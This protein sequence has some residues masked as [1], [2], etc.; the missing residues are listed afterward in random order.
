MHTIPREG[1]R[2]RL[3]S[4]PDDPDPIQVGQIGTVVDV[5]RHGDGPDG[6]LQIDVEWDDGRTL[7]LVSPPD[8][9]EIVHAG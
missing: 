9:F 5:T 3:Q 8:W 7:M 1:D 6:W 4:M 2:I